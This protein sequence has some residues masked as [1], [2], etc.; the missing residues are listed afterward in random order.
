[1]VLGMAA[2]DEVAHGGSAGEL[3]L[4]RAELAETRALMTKVIDRL[5][6]AALPVVP[7]RTEVDERIMEVLAKY[8]TEGDDTAWARGAPVADW[9]D[10]FVG[11]AVDRP[12]NVVG[13]LEAGEELPFVDP[14]G[15][16][17]AVT[18]WREKGEGA[19]DEWAAERFV[20]DLEPTMN[21]AAAWI[22]PLE[23]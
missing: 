3:A 6:D 1:M 19:F 4:I 21:G 14:R 17:E 20:P 11:L 23:I 9:T 7:P 13:R 8:D 2:A 16:E 12:A 22:E 5:L 15:A 10:P 18:A